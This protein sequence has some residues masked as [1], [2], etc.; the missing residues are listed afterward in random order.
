[1]PFGLGSTYRILGRYQDAVRTLLTLLAET[2]GD[3]Q[4]QEYRK[5]IEYYAGDLDRTV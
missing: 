2:S 5:A 1:M 4:V 3:R